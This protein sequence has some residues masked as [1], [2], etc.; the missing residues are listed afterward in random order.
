MSDDWLN[1]YHQALEDA[2]AVCEQHAKRCED[3]AYL[4]GG[5]DDP[6]PRHATAIYLAGRIRQMKD[7]GV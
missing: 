5:L 6:L 7:K 2:A 3:A 4:G 1:G